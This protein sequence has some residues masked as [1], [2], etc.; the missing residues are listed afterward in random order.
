MAVPC[1]RNFAPT[2]SAMSGLHGERAS[3]DQSALPGTQIRQ[4]GETSK[5]EKRLSE[6]RYKVVRMN[7]PMRLRKDFDHEKRER[8]IDNGRFEKNFDAF[9]PVRR[10]LYA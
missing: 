5:E 4:C 1:L 6:S 8:F 9:W 2:C 7:Q 3:P 10:H